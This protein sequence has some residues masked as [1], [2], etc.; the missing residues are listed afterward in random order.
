LLSTQ[1]DINKITFYDTNALH[2]VEAIEMHQTQFLLSHCQ[3]YKETRKDKE[4]EQGKFSMLVGLFN[5][6][7]ATLVVKWPLHRGHLSDILHIISLNP[8]LS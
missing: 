5:L 7:V 3:S 6:W 2:V 1:G 8:P 4:K